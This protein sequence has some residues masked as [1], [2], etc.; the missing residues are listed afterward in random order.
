MGRTWTGTMGVIELRNGTLRFPALAE[1]KGPAVLLLHGFPDTCQTFSAQMKALADSGYQAIAPTMRGYA[2]E[3][4]PLDGDCHAIRMA[5]DVMAWADQSGSAQVHLI[6]HDWGACIAMSAAA[7]APERIASLTM[8]AV[9]HPV[10]FAAVL[11]QD[12]EQRAR[13]A[14]MTDLRRVD[15]E[16]RV[17]ADD[18]RYLEKLWCCWSP[19]WNVPRSALAAMREA[20][21][22]PGV[23]PAAL[24]YY[25]QASDRDSPAARAT[26]AL[27]AEPLRVPTLAIHGS[28]DG[29]IG[30]EAFRAAMLE[31]DFAAGLTIAEI[32]DAGHFVHA[33]APDEVNGL[34]LD[35]LMRH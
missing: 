24:E 9:P 13:S 2:P 1:G 20:F 5:E 6:G 7:L 3:A 30:P 10:R 15:A 11:A 12:A 25:R 23:L 18:F 8:I 34:I 14:Y 19:G 4:I 29:C 35:W 17:A 33:E 32:P 22:R 31:E 21:S 27:Y 28:Q 26:S 16:L